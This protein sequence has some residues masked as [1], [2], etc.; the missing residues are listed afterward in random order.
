MDDT[1]RVNGPD[2][3]ERQLT[4]L[5]R[6]GPEH[7]PFE[8]RHR[9]RLYAGVRA[10][11]RVRAARRAAGSVLAVAGLGLGLL[12]WPHGSTD[13]LPS[14]PRP[15]PAVSPAPSATTPPSPDVS[16]S[17]APSSSATS[18][19]PGSSATSGPDPSGTSL[20]PDPGGTTTTEEPPATTGSSATA[21]APGDAPTSRSPG[22]G[23]TSSPP[24]P[25]SPTG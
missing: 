7:H 6:G 10:R 22:E 19:P 15:R 5:L 14:A 24:A 9:E 13:D 3:F 20:P 16:P 4:E 18:E 23:V 17:G 25:P 1:T 8:A 12:L 2:Q 11:R 21:T